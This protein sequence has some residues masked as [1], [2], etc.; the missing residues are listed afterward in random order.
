MM[1]NSNIKKIFTLS[2]FALSFANVIAQSESLS[3]FKLN[4][5]AEVLN[6]QLNDLEFISADKLHFFSAL[7]NDTASLWIR[8][9]LQIN[10]LSSYLSANQ[11]NTVNILSPLYQNYVSSQSMRTIK[12][13]LGSVSFGATAYLA[14]KHL[15][16]YG[17]LKKK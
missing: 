5:P 8:T 15:K 3:G 12:T 11:N 17:F 9:N 16:K 1:M 6:L 14:Y 13:I 2:L 7:M 4:P 10:A